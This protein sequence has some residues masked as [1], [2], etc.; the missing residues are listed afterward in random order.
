MPKVLEQQITKLALVAGYGELPIKLAKSAIAEGIEVIALALNNETYRQL[1]SITK[2]YKFNPIDIFQMIEVIQTNKIKHLTM[3][4]KVPKLDFFK[5]LHRLDLRLLA[6]VKELKDMNDDS[7]H[8]RL[9]DFLEQEYGLTIID[10]TKYLRDLFPGSQTF[11]K[12]QASTEELETIEF[13]LSRAKGLAALDIGQTVVAQNK[14]IT[15]V[16]A[17]EGTNECIKRAKELMHKKK[18][19]STMIVCKVSKPNQDNRFDVPTVGL[20]TLK[21]IGKDAILAF[22]AGECFFIDQEKAIAYADKN[23]ICIIA[24]EV[25]L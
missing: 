25:K 9:A 21:A 13:S 7:L 17:I 20:K 2:T 24:T 10:Q 16:E 14:A 1:K 11:T 6:K 12:R 19:S 8:H 5:D 15:A 3:I 4:G 18:Q 22:E 23:N